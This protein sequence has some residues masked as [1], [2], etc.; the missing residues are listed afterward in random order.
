MQNQRQSQLLHWLK[1]KKYAVP[2]SFFFRKNG[3]AG[4]MPL[5]RLQNWQGK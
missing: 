4:Y 3:K 2:L 1:K 5:M